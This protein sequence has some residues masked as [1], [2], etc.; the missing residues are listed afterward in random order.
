MREV[1]R[2]TTRPARATRTRPRAATPF[3]SSVGARTPAGRDP[4]TPR[5]SPG[6]ADAGT[7]ESIKKCERQPHYA[8]RSSAA[9]CAAAGARAANPRSLRVA[10]APLTTL[11]HA[12]A[13]HDRR[14]EGRRRQI[15]AVFLQL[16]DSACLRI[17]SIPIRR[18]TRRR[19]R[20]GRIGHRQYGRR[21][22]CEPRR[23]VVSPP[24]PG[25]P[26]RD[27]IATVGVRAGGVHGCPLV[28]S[29]AQSGS[30]RAAAR[31]GERPIREPRRDAGGDEV[32]ATPA[33]RPSGAR[34]SP[35][36]PNTPTGRVAIPPGARTTA[37]GYV[38]RR[39]TWR[40][41]WS[42]RLFTRRL[43]QLARLATDPITR[44]TGTSDATASPTN[45]TP[46]VAATSFSMCGADAGAASTSS[47]PTSRNPAA[48][49]CHRGFG[50]DLVVVD[51]GSVPLGITKSWPAPGTGRAIC[52]SETPY[53]KLSTRPCGSSLLHELLDRRRF[54]E[55]VADG[56]AR[57][58][59]R[60]RCARRRCPI[61]TVGPAA[62]IGIS[63]DLRA[64][65]RLRS[66]AAKRRRVMLP[67]P[68]AMSAVRH[69]VEVRSEE[70]RVTSLAAS[71]TQTR[72]RAH[73]SR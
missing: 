24:S 45:T 8:C 23:F 14:R 49:R 11:N 25:V 53:R 55:Q 69:V 42:W 57:D 6:T 67:L 4:R 33:P 59:M 29:F 9:A 28:A 13:L 70:A 54:G 56:D 63:P 26:S 7:P 62:T 51:G 10:N 60:A 5:P 27:C 15:L 38:G 21:C 71:S 72:A 52:V 73:G 41:T 65:R 40:F 32:S 20:I 47:A 19:T 61:A 35:V 2:G 58:P 3:H 37:S 44:A 68:D 50:Q 48:E 16:Q 31:S 22:G 46:S 1:I 64:A 17:C 43:T 12:H 18:R 66:N 30:R 36:P 34:H 39:R